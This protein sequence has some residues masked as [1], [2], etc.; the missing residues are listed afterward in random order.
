MDVHAAV[1]RL[2]VANK[3]PLS[4]IDKITYLRR[5]IESSGIFA[6][7]IEMF[8]ADFSIGSNKHTYAALA[9]ACKRFAKNTSSATDPIG[10]ANL[11]KRKFAEKSAEIPCPSETEKSEMSLDQKVADAVSKGFALLAAKN[12]SKEKKKDGKLHYCHSHGSKS[13]HPSGRCEKPKPGHQWNAT[14]ANKMGGSTHV[15]GKGKRAGQASGGEAT[16]T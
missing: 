10:S 15:F 13:N 7:P 12:K 14:E 16:N 2:R 5:A 4:E 8:M 9:L 6:L 3:Q 1:H 11:A